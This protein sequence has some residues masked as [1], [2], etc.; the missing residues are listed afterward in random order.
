LMIPKTEFS[1][2][3]FLSSNMSVTSPTTKTTDMSVDPPPAVS[4]TD[5]CASEARAP[6]SENSKNVPKKKKKNVPKKKKKVE[7]ASVA[8]LRRETSAQKIQRLFLWITFKVRL[9]RLRLCWFVLV[10]MRT[11]NRAA[12]KIQQFLR[13]S[14]G[15]A[16]WEGTNDIVRWGHID[17]GGDPY[18]DV[19]TFPKERPTTPRR[20]VVEVESGV[21]DDFDHELC[22]ARVWM[23]NPKLSRNGDKNLPEQGEVRQCSNKKVGGC[24]CRSH[25]KRVQDPAV[26]DLTSFPPKRKGLYQGRWDD[27]FKPVR[28][29]ADT[30]RWFLLWNTPGKLFKQAILDWIIEVGEIHGAIDLYIPFKGSN[31]RFEAGVKEF[32][33]QQGLNLWSWQTEKRAPK[34]IL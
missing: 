27:P 23:C 19:N 17:R 13:I 1:G 32:L 33:H 22:A 16:V 5:I 2:L 31:G 9:D 4:P 28:F 8:K 26:Y 34:P 24:Y 20:R 11:V 29:D 6:T 3:T 30:K 14:C 15:R 25:V 21:A 10:Y 12:L 7:P 18:V